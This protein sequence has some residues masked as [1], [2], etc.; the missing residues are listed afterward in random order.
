MS[1]SHSTD[2]NG[3][4]VGK[5]IQLLLQPLENLQFR[6][7]R[8]LEAGFLHQSQLPTPQT[9][10][11]ALR[12]ALMTAVGINPKNFKWDDQPS[13]ANSEDAFRHLVTCHAHNAHPWI[14]DVRFRGPWLV[15]RY[16][17]AWNRASELMLPLPAAIQWVA[18]RHRW[19]TLRPLAGTL[20]WFSTGQGYAPLWHTEVEPSQAMEGYVTRTAM[21]EYLSMRSPSWTFE[22]YVNEADDNDWLA[23]RE[24]LLADVRSIGIARDLDRASVETGRLYAPGELAFHNGLNTR[25]EACPSTCFYAEIVPTSKEATAQLERFLPKITSLTFGGQGAEVLVKKLESIDGELSPAIDVDNLSNRLVVVATSPIIMDG[26]IPKPLANLTQG[27]KP[28]CRLVSACVSKAVS[29]SGWDAFRR[30]SQPN[31]FAAPAGS[32]YFL[33][34][35]ADKQGQ[36]SAKQELLKLTSL[37]PEPFAQHGWGTFV[38]GNY[39]PISYS[40]LQQES[41]IGSPTDHMTQEERKLA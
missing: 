24:E 16:P 13:D 40:F 22:D 6:D 7:G 30:C 41:S 20:E 29:V 33:E 38:V 19:V 27:D 17:A 9:L 35:D 15:R 3:T 34:F 36:D 21:Q 28:G 10:T 25:G 32:C 14:A 37:S 8:P 18:E 39:R 31:R 12:L 23:T 4:A 2:G 1:E 26:K 5:T 11:G